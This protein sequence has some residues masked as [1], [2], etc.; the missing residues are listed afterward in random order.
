MYANYQWDFS[1]I[2]D[3]MPLF[4][5]A[6]WISIKILLLAGV[7][8]LAMGLCIGQGLLSKRWYVFAPLRVWVEVFRLTPPLLQIVLIYFLLP[9]VTGLRLPAFEAGVIALS[10]NYSAFFS[11]VFRAG[12]LSL[13][14]GQGEAGAAMGMTAFQ[15][16]KR[17][18]YPQAIRRMLPPITNM[19]VNLT[20]DT[21]LLTI[22]GVAE[23]FNVSQSVSARSF[24]NVEVLLVLAVFYL[25]I[26]VPLSY[27]ANRLY[28][29]Q[30]VRI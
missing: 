3:E 18:I 2:A 12:V 19:L 29:R 9:L 25:V 27:V 8:S 21:S 30:T 4:G 16:L 1:W 5:M 6:A 23:L 20:K 15:V 28:A 7:L 17:V 24:K 11:E 26:N 13:G 22:I 10:L 14:K